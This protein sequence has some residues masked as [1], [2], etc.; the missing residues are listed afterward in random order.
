MESLG[1]GDE[2]DA[3]AAGWTVCDGRVWRSARAVSTGPFRVIVLL[4]ETERMTLRLLFQERST[5]K[6]TGGSE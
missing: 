3:G 6:R 4:A 2:L 5:K 1:P